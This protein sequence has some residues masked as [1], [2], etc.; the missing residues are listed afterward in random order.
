MKGKLQTTLRAPQCQE[1]RVV[2]SVTQRFE[3][4]KLNSH[5]FS[6]EEVC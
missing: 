5:V 6:K 2:L 4:I 1:L 3:L